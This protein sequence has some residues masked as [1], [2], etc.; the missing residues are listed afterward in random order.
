MHSDSSTNR[1]ARIAVGKNGVHFAG[2]CFEVA[3]ALLDWS[4][5]LDDGVG[6]PALA[7]DTADACRGAAFARLLLR[8][9]RGEYLVKVEDGTDVGIARV[10]AANARRIGDHRLQLSA[11]LGLRIRQ[12]NGIPVALRHLPAVGSRQLWRRVH[13]NLWFGQNSPAGRTE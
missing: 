5:F 7:L 10:L 11:N 13:H 6:D 2:I 9:L 4:E 1:R 3:T 12:E 8:L